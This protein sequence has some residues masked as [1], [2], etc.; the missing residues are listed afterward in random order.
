M[1]VTTCFGLLRP[2]SGFHPNFRVKCAVLSNRSVKLN[3]RSTLLLENPAA[4]QRAKI[5]WYDS[6][7]LQMSHA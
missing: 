5:Q 3:Q 7:A 2:S 1:I 4:P 6:F